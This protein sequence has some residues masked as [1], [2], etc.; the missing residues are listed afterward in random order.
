MDS[1]YN[2]A[3]N[4]TG[5]NK[6][7]GAEKDDTFTGG[8]VTNVKNFVESLRSGQYLNNASIGAKSTLT[9]IL[10]RTAAYKG[11]EVTWEEMLRQA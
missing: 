9:S 7:N 2:G 11:A 3:I 8:A 10:G 1:H 4:M 6:W 5:D